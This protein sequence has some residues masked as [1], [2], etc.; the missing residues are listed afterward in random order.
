MIK[1]LPQTTDSIPFIL[2]KSVVADV[3]TFSISTK[4]FHSYEY[5]K[6]D[7]SKLFYDIDVIKDEVVAI[8]GIEGVMRPFL[9]QIEG[10]IF[11][12]FFVLFLLGAMVFVYGGFSHFSGI[13]TLFSFN[14]YKDEFDKDL[15]IT[16]SD[17]WSKFFYFVQTLVIYSVFFFAIIVRNSNIFI[18][19]YD[20]LILSLQI[21][22]G[23]LLFVLGKYLV[24]KLLEVVFSRSRY[25]NLLNA[26][27][28]VFYFLGIAGFIP[29]I[30][31]I[32]IPEITV[33]V[34]YFL[35]GIFLIGRIALFI[36]S[37]L[38][39]KKAH[40]GSSY[41]FVYLCGIEIMPYLLL[42]KAIV[43]IN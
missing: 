13:G 4:D 2:Q 11:L 30:L 7:S 8:S 34:L 42:Y 25:N 43:L 6:L 16:T 22:A 15:V 39:F 12:I 21:I 1:L 33:Y 24:Y 10:F 37:Y 9:D 31:Y 27:L 23:L 5:L 29:I 3:D 17:A 32:Y 40:I 36:Q 26:Y 19:V 14:N 35:L 38:F 28:S 41:F 18:N 20:Y